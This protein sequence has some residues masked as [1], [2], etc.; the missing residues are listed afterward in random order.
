[1]KGRILKLLF[2][3]ALSM[4]LANAALADEFG[5]RLAQVEARYGVIDPARAVADQASSEWMSVGAAQQAIIERD[6]GNLDEAL[7]LIGMAANIAAAD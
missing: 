2:A 3:G 7:R 1:M 5:D 6:N 4:G